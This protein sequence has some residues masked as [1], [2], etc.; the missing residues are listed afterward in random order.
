MH[1]LRHINTHGSCTACKFFFAIFFPFLTRHTEET[2]RR[3]REKPREGKEC[4]GGGTK[5]FLS[6]SITRE[7]CVT[8]TGTTS[9]HHRSNE[10]RKWTISY[11]FS[12]SCCACVP[13]PGPC[14][15]VISRSFSVCLSLLRKQLR[16]SEKEKKRKGKGKKREN[17][18]MP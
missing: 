6:L 3:S 15:F 14:P 7:T 12:C 11:S 4:R 18:R 16:N 1:Q 8:P 9:V 17:T 2:R 10:D 5:N 13:A